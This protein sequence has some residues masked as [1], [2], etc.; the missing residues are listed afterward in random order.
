MEFGGRREKG[1]IFPLIC[2]NPITMVSSIASKHDL[3]V[4]II[5]KNMRQQKF[6]SPYSFRS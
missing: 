5:R 1:K 3:F 4:V 6:Y 2:L